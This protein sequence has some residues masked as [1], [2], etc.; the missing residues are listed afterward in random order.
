M[1]FF[2]LPDD[3]DLTL[4]ARQWLDRLRRQRGIDTVPK[5]W[6]VYARVPRI[7]EA[8]VT[9]EANLYKPPAGE[10]AFSWEARNVAFMLVAH[11]RR[12][13]GCFGAS[14][15]H[16]AALGFDEPTLD[17]FCANPAGLPLSDRER[18]FVKYVLQI[19][20]DPTQLQPKH[21]HSRDQRILER[22][23][24]DHRPAAQPFRARRDDI[25]L[26][27]HLEHA[28]AHQP[29]QRRRRGQAQRGCRQH[30]PLDAALAG[31]GKP[32]QPE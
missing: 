25:L 23:A 22:V 26:A 2:A 5:S 10:S 8:R 20:A 27:Q 18:L 1:A 17:G 12:C 30:E 6:L 29:R 11:A 31:G 14:R 24:H 13:D 16:L 4:E 15:R 28:R 9:A 7:L 19:A 3:A 32:R 21:G